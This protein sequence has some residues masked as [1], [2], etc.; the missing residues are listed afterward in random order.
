MQYFTSLEDSNQFY[1]TNMDLIALYQGLP[2]HCSESDALGSCPLLSLF[3]YFVN[4]S[5]FA[6]QTTLTVGQMLHSRSREMKRDVCVCVCMRYSIRLRHGQNL[7][8]PSK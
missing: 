3:R 7:E 5:P 6:C 8:F 2:L 1:L 4:D